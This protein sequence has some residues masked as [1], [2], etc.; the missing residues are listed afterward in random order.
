MQGPVGPDPNNTQLLYL[1]EDQ[2]FPFP[3]AVSS[4]Y[5]DGADLLGQ[6][7]CT[8]PPSPPTPPHTAPSVLVA[9]LIWFFMKSIF[10][11]P[12]VVP[13]RSQR[14]QVNV[15]FHCGIQPCSFVLM[16]PIVFWAASQPSSLPLKNISE[17][18]PLP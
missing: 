12:A 13:R 6:L 15:F 1:R 17:Q 16:R 2:P 5:D 3:V 18:G 10:E 11:V 4:A 9:T 8:V 14:R 7:K